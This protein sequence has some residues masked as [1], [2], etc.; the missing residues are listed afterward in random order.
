VCPSVRRGSVVGSVIVMGASILNQ[1]RR[2][3]N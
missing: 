2:T 1:G 3:L